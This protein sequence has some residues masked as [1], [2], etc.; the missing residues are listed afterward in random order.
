MKKFGL[1][2][3]AVI[4]L[5]VAVTFTQN[6]ENSTPDKI[7]VKSI[8]Q[9]ETE[10]L[11]KETSFN[12]TDTGRLTPEA[13][14]QESE[15]IR[16]RST[17][18]VMEGVE[19][20]SITLPITGERAKIAVFSAQD[21]SLDIEL[22]DPSGGDIPVA[23]HSRNS[24]IPS[25]E[26]SQVVMGRGGVKDGVLLVT[27]RK[28]MTPGNYIVNVRQSNAPIDIIVNDEGG[29]ELNIWLSD[30]GRDSKK[31]VTIYAELKD[32]QSSMLNAQLVARVKGTD[33]K[34]ILTETTP[35]VYSTNFSTAKFEGLQTLIV[36]AKGR[37]TQGLDLL[38]NGSIDVIAG[39]SNAKL[40]G[41]GQETLTDSDLVVEV[42]VKVTTP[43]RYYVRGNILGN[44]GEP[45][46]WAQ[47]A[48]ELTPGN[49]TLTLKFAKE[50]L[51]QSGV[52]SGF[53]LSGVE[54][55]NTTNMPGIK[56]AEKIDNFF[57]KSSL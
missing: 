53:K 12:R 34:I 51:N 23:P 13:L 9:L 3:I 55:M 46:A 24:Q 45:I 52:T 17:M 21:G 47:D 27:D 14:N 26:M 4:L 25:H 44:T 37:T 19:S 36:E 30:N 22:S 56:A 2:L 50:I 1:L 38:R 48:Q 10:R 43:G 33:T 8:P 28:Q 29:P 5:V 18:F 35:G 42:K 11:V 41:V 57:L 15:T 31:G 49:H 7:K 40:L 54:L 16:T 20:N 39:K 6:V 32:G